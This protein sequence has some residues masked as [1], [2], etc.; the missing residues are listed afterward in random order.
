MA[1][2][3]YALRTVA[4]T[5]TVL[6]LPGTAT[7][8]LLEACVNEASDL[9]ERAWGRHV[10]SRG[11]LTEYH[12]RDPAM[13][14]LG[15]DLYVNEWPLVSVTTVHEDVNGEHG[16]DTLLTVTTDYLVS[17][18]AG[19]IIRMSGGRPIGWSNA[20]RAVKV[21]YIGGYQNTAGTVT[22]AQDVPFG[23]L[24]VFDE[25]VGW[26]MQQRTRAEHGMT[27]TSDATGSRQFSGPAY[28]TPGMQA[29]LDSCGAVSVSR[30]IQTG[31]RD[32]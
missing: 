32:A 3:A 4:A 7:D 30:R 17:K 5:R 11:A 24:R 31:D 27:S 14:G 6:R 12:P 25:L 16:S 26:M 23:V 29:A 13:Y 10:V 15:C 8:D 19:R 22:G 28:I 21:V 20:W 1:L 18:P 2:W 9:V